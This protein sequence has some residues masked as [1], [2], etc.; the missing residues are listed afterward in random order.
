MFQTKP[1]KSGKPFKKREVALVQE[2]SEMPQLSAELSGEDRVFSDNLGSD[3][4]DTETVIEPEG[5]PEGEPE[6]AGEDVATA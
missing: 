3:L 1:T 6:Q 4:L 2:D 5:E